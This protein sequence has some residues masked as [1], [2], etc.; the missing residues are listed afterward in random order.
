M[1]RLLMSP[2]VVFSLFTETHHK[3]NQQ[4]IKALRQK[5][6]DMDVNLSPVAV[7]GGRRNHR[8]SSRTSVSATTTTLKPSP[9]CHSCSDDQ[10]SFTSDTDREKSLNSCFNDS[11]PFPSHHHHHNP[12]STLLVPHHLQQHSHHGQ[13][14][15]NNPLD[16]DLDSPDQDYDFNSRFSP[17]P[18]DTSYHSENHCNCYEDADNEHHD[19]D[20]SDEDHDDF[21]GNGTRR[22]NQYRQKRRG[23]GGVKVGHRNC[24]ML[25]VEDEDEVGVQVTKDTV[26]I[27]ESEA[28]GGVSSAREL[29]EKTMAAAASKAR[30]SQKGAGVNAGAGV[31]V[32]GGLSPGSKSYHNICGGSGRNG[33]S[34]NFGAVSGSNCTDAACGKLLD[35]VCINNSC[36]GCNKRAPTG[37]LAPAVAAASAV[38]GDNGAA[39]NNSSRSN[40]RNHHPHHLQHGINEFM[41]GPSGAGP[42][43]VGAMQLASYGPQVII[44]RPLILGFSIQLISSYSGG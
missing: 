44:N 28:R 34:A 32:G 7:S 33:Q 40:N 5:L 19:T 41:H 38:G 8:Q 1:N 13:Q 25:A 4:Q 35:K 3:H 11:N 17:P 30:Q 20:D 9:S 21:I 36:S 16:R 22:P 24:T 31:G 18:T 27:I 39:V 37:A 12:Q 42:Q 6:C 15:Q 23:G 43:P 29:N 10:H 26:C 14:G 2:F